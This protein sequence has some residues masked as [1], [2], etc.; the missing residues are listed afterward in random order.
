MI[1]QEVGD[2]I[3]VTPDS[4]QRK[5]VRLIQQRRE[6]LIRLIKF[7]IVG[8]SGVVVTLTANYI[9]HA[10]I[11][12]PLYISTPL[13]VEMAIFTNFLGNHLW[14]FDRRGE[15]ERSVPRLEN[16]AIVGPLFRLLLRPIV[17]QFFKFN[18]VS[19]VGLVITT[20]ITTFVANQ[21][22]AELRM[23]AGEAYFL[24]A[25]LAGIAVALSWN[26]AANAK[27]TWRR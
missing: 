22:N 5:I 14:T 21:Y 18:T 9:L 8:M 12:L 20:V 13:A 25:N 27:W 6:T 3:Q 24:L 26:F 4:L 17:R 2:P 10:L 11:L 16:A 1:A 7:G 23:I 19:L 15:R